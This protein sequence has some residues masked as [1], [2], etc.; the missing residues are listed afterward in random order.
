MTIDDLKE[1]II[2]L[3]PFITAIGGILIAYWTH[4]EAMKPSDKDIDRAVKRVLEK[5]EKEEKEHED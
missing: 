1:L 2:D 5:K 3:T 4:K